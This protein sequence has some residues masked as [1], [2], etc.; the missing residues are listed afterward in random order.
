MRGR[1]WLSRMVLAVVLLAAVLAGVDR[2]AV[3]VAQ[4]QAAE[5]ARK[6]ITA[7]ST[8]P[9]VEIHGFPFLTQLP[10]GTLDH[11]TATTKDVEVRGFDLGELRCDLYGVDW[12]GTSHHVDHLTAAGTLDVHGITS[13]LQRQGI[14]VANVKVHGPKAAGGAGTIS[15]DRS[16]FGITASIGFAVDYDAESDKLVLRPDSVSVAGRSI[17]FDSLPK[18]LRSVADSYTIDVSR[19]PY[20]ARLDRVRVTDTGLEIT[21]NARD[22]TFS[23]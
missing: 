18:A 15:F 7:L 1:R 20:G 17:G 23:S 3:H 16:Y 21:A 13:A 12:R 14:P 5:H 8:E 9:V 22:V 6:S 2:V 11:V 19:L 4:Q 10:G